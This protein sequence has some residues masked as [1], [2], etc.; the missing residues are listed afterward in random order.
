M[1]TTSPA[2]ARPGPDAVEPACTALV[3]FGITGDLARKKTFAALHELQHFGWAG[4]PV[5][6][7]GRS[8]WTDDDIRAAA[9]DAV[10][11][12]ADTA[13]LE[14]FS[15]VRGDY[16]DAA[17]YRRLER[18]LAEHP[19]VLCY[20]AV[21][22]TVF[23]D[24][25][26]GLA[27][28]DLR[29]RVR[30]MIEKPFGTD[31]RSAER[32]QARLTAH[33]DERCVYAVDHYLQKEAVQNISV[34]RFANRILEAVWSAA[35][36][37]SI[38]VTMAESFGVEGRAG[39]FDHAGTLRDVVQSHVLQIV[40]GL[41]ME[42]PTPGSTDDVN[43]RRCELLAA[44]APLQPADVVFGQYDGYTSQEGVDAD[45]TTDTYVRARLTIDN[46]RWRGTAWTL[47]AGKALAE[48]CTSVEI[49]F[50][51]ASG[52]TGADD[53]P[54]PAPNRFVLVLS[55]E[56]SIT[57]SLRARSSSVALGSTGADMVSDASYRAG[58]ALSPYA[59]VF[60]DVR[61]GD[62]TPFTRFD[63]VEA[64]WRVV[65]PL[66]ERRAPPRPYRRGTW[67]PT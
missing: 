58:D 43:E 47:V 35:H 39:F 3:V 5:I 20:L 42:P 50:R 63:V 6:G 9:A 45:S 15:Y 32:L 17:L 25:V 21:P 8:A 62:H 40:V 30:L 1:S 64:A 55:P 54:A 49:T 36:I 34:V 28:T 12:D 22:P 46:P 24:V 59:R 37:D 14:R 19:A 29:D 26:V 4:V 41:A 33:F 11:G 51:A 38:I 18:A 65:Q 2:G 52:H 53:D 61:R 7:V 66:L 57:L 56:E 16:T 23:E 44:I 48:T 31:L 67:G 60:D 10:G 27:A 13:F